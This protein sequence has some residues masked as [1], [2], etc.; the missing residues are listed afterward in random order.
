M[1]LHCIRRSAGAYRS[2]RSLFFNLANVLLGRAGNHTLH[3]VAYHG[4]SNTNGGNYLCVL[5]DIIL[6]SH[7]FRAIRY[8]RS[9]AAA[10]AHQ[11][12]TVMIQLIFFSQSI[13]AGINLLKILVQN[14]CRQLLHS[15]AHFICNRLHCL[16][17][18]AGIS[19]G[20]ILFID[21]SQNVGRTGIR[22][23]DALSVF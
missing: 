18:R 5:R 12:H 4:K 22:K 14:L 2:I 1:H 13:D 8:Q 11:F 20:K 19:V 7:L 10:A 9:R 16:A 3:H 17:R 21:Q 23:A 15:D 6:E